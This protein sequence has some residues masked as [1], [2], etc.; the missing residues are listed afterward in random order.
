MNKMLISQI[1]QKLKEYHKGYGTIDEATTRDKILFGNPDQECTGI[2]ISCWASVDVIKEAIARNANLIICHEALFWNH[3]DHQE[4]LQEAQN[5]TY[6][7]KKKLLEEHGI[8]VWRDHDY[9][10]SGIPVDGKWVD[11]IFYGLA[12]ELGWLDRMLDQE[13]MGTTVF[14]LSDMTVKEAAAHM[15]DKM[16][17]NG[18]KILGNPD[19]NAG[20]ARVQFHVL[21]DAN[22]MINEAERLDTNLLICMELIDFTLAEYVRDSAQLGR[23]RTA[24]T[25]GHFNTEEPGMKYCL[26]YFPQVIGED[27]PM[28]FVQSGDMYHYLTK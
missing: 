17:L 2:V 21:G 19:E 9:I 10:H 7:E 11:G 1:I 28:T 8:V 25:A 6:L 3:G 16:N 12:K 22:D 13:P 26:E 20:I 24:L 23:K 18:L 5:P 4:W 14:D 15:V 27:I